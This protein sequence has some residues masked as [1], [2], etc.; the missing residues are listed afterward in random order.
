MVTKDKAKK[1]K[2]GDVVTRFWYTLKNLHSKVECKGYT[3]NGID[4]SSNNLYYK[5]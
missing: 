4:K 1:T 3:T 5:S 2:K